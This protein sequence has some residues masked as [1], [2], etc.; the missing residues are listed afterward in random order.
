LS[1]LANKP[2]KFMKYAMFF[3][4]LNA[5]FTSMAGDSPDDDKRRRA[6]L[7]D[8]KRG[9]VWGGDGW[10]IAPKLMRMPWNDAHGSPVYLDIRRFVPLGDVY[11]VGQ[12]HSAIPMLP[13]LQ[14]SGPLG[15]LAEL[16]LNKSSFTGKEITLETDTGTEKA[17]KV[18]KHMWSAFTP[19]LL[20][21]PGSY[22]TSNVVDSLQG[23]TDAFGRELS[24]EQ[25]ISNSFGVKLGSYP[26]DVLRQR[27]AAQARAPMNEIQKQI[28]AINRQYQINAIT[29]EDARA[30][31]AAQT[32]KQQEIAEELRRR[33][34]P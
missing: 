9:Y 8:E 7:A 10:G 11:D 24:P 20:G 27:A 3:G 26:E 23:K 5:L 34:N 33:M 17:S 19:N 21:L 28:S 1:T 6:L 30:K 4:G 31:I 22:A 13:A 18:A 16:S 25:A 2:H 29:E 32:A 14:L 15:I 12:T